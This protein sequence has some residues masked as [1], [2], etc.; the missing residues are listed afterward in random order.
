MTSAISNNGSQNE[1]NVYPNPSTGFYNI[2]AKKIFSGNIMIFDM[3]GNPVF[4]KN[5]HLKENEITQIDL[6]S[7]SNGIYFLKFESDTFDSS[8]IKLIKN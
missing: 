5:I 4:E 2:I 8:Y 7:K 6:S 3:L 1:I